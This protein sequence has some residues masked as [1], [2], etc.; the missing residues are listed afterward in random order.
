MF[1]KIRTAFLLN[2]GMGSFIVEMNFIQYFYDKFSDRVDISVFSFPEETSVA[3]YGR[4]YFIS[5]YGSRSEFQENEFDLS[6]DLNWF[7]KIVYRNEK[8]FAELD[9]NDDL[10]SLINKWREFANNSR[11]KNFFTPD[12]NMFD[13]N[14]HMFLIA[15]NQS[16]LQSADIGGNL[17]VEKRFLLSITAEN[18]KETL[19]KFGLA[20]CQYIT[21]Q[22]GVDF[23]C[24]TKKSPKQW[25]NEYYSKLCGICKNRFPNIKTVQLGEK[26]NNTPI[27]GVDLCLLGET[28]LKELKAV[29]KNALIHVDGD[30]GMVHLRRAMHAGANIVLYGNL[31]DKVYGY[32]ED[33][34]IKSNV[35]SYECAKLFNAWKSRCYKNY[36][37]KAPECMTAISPESIANIIAEYIGDL[38]SGRV[39]IDRPLP[40]NKAPLLAYERIMSEP[41]IKLDKD[42]VEGWLKKWEENGIYDYMFESV[43]LSELRFI[44]LTSQGYIAVPLSK[45]PAY[46]YL[47]G[48]VKAYS[49]YMKVNQKYNPQGE[50][51]EKRFYELLE[52]LSRNGYDDTNIIAVDAMY[53]ILDGAHRAAWLMNKFGEDYEV[54]I[55]KIYCFSTFWLE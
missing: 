22:Q 34:R 26:E 54:T 7:P 41:N 43:K 30:C 52:S 35:C 50:R 36:N 12:T 17:G 16:R 2:G 38:S 21:L 27:D 33:Y 1:D 10:F 5:N 25:P 39:K 14:I 53:K 47:Q 42:W 24:N 44:K 28:D 20:D 8:R 51:S 6:I 3:L 15:K 9:E 46:Q 40:I 37:C 55:L 45:S 18:E 19:K 11:T 13:P 29:L 31:P 49:K 48:D 4:Q 23:A 32:D